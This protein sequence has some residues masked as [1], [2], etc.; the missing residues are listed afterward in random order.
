MQVVR[1]NNIKTIRFLVL[2]IIFSAILQ[3]C[4]NDMRI[5]TKE[6]DQI[7]DKNDINVFLER[8]KHKKWLL[9]LDFWT[10]MSEQEFK[11]IQDSLIN[12]GS[13]NK[14]DS[15]NHN[16]PIYKMV[17]NFSQD[18]ILNSSFNVFPYFEYDHLLSIELD[19]KALEGQ[20]ALSTTLDE[21]LGMM[22]IPAIIAL[23]E[24]KYGKP[25]QIYDKLD[26][27]NK[28]LIWK[29]GYKVIEIKYN[30]YSRSSKS[31][32]GPLAHFE[33]IYY[34]SKYYYRLQNEEKLRLESKRKDLKSEREKTKD[35][36]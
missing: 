9:F 1:L 13:L 22:E 15:K 5:K 36:I 16:F 28:T 32:R 11:T 29:L 10:F 34:E 20:N 23:Y 33:I 2:L 35:A 3:S 24:S 25:C 4:K 21:N 17:L 19:Y 8:N 7:S 12:W 26:S 30:Y 27:D 14:S 6:I 18:F 31:K